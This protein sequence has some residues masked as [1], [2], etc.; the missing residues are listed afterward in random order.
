MIV[1][2]EQQP[3]WSKQNGGEEEQG[4]QDKQWLD[5]LQEADLPP[6]TTLLHECLIHPIQEQVGQVTEVVPAFWFSFWAL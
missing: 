5:S 1:G 2:F 4:W 3:A 6:V